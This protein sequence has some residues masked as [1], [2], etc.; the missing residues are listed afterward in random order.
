MVVQNTGALIFRSSWSLATIVSPPNESLSS[1]VPKFLPG[2][3]RPRKWTPGNCHTETH[4]WKTEM[5]ITW[6]SWLWGSRRSFVM[7][8]TGE[9]H[10]D[11]CLVRHNVCD[12]NSQFVSGWDAQA[13][14]KWYSWWTLSRGGRISK[15]YENRCIASRRTTTIW[16]NDTVQR[17]QIQNIL[18]HLSLMMKSKIPI[19]NICTVYIYV[20]LCSMKYKNLSYLHVHG[21]FTYVVNVNVPGVF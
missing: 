2:N 1:D 9:W 8:L 20:A 5:N 3:P 11:V 19:S 10:L 15:M 12:F 21:R 7:F 14:K 13:L 18:Q 4:H 17:T 16:A 6:T